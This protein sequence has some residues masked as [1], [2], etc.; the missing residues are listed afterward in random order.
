[1]LIASKNGSITATKLISETDEAWTLVVEK[2]NVASAKLTAVI[3][4][5]TIFLR[6]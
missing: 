2:R 6:P 5:S 1:M 3:V 4:L